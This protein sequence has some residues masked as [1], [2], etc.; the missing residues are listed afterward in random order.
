MLMVGI[1]L[2]SS[3][4]CILNMN[5]RFLILA[6]LATAPPAFAVVSYTGGTYT[7]NFDSLASTGADTA[8]TDDVTLDGWTAYSGDTGYTGTGAFT[9]GLGTLNTL[10]DGY[11]A[12]TGAST[13]GEL[14]SYGSTGSNERALGS[15][16]SGTSDEFFFAL[17][18][19]NATGLAATSFDLSYDG[20]QWR[21]GANAVPRA[22][23]LLFFYRVGGSV[24]DDTGTWTSVSLLDFVSPDNSSASAA[25]LDGNVVK[26]ALSQT[27]NASI[28]PGES[29]WLAWVD[30]D[31][32]GTDYGLAI[33]NVNL[34]LATVPEP[35]SALLAAGGAALA[36]MRRR[37]S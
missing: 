25:V 37:R 11:D 5:K 35:G 9:F 19:T 23:S 22:E 13:T 15:L 6:T 21:R 14:Y 12:D 3:H 30:P 36:L 28:A 10:A 34:S 31:N 27:V 32:T 33:D 4:P 2:R 16:A 24:F 20:E 8:F 29:L 1:L 18:V 26:T 7:Q 17:Q